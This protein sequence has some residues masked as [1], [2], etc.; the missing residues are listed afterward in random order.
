[1]WDK[2]PLGRISATVCHAARRSPRR[3]AAPGRMVRDPT[4]PDMSS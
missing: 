1:M 2:M 4:V 3:S